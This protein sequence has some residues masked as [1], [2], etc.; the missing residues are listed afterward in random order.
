MNNTEK[1]EF[2]KEL[3]LKKQDGMDL[4]MKLSMFII[5][6][7]LFFQSLAAYFVLTLLF[8][9]SLSTLNVGWFQLFFII[10]LA[11]LISSTMGFVMLEK[12]KLIE[13]TNRIND[14]VIHLIVD[15]K[16]DIEEYKVF[17]SMMGYVSKSKKTVASK[18]VQF[19][20]DVSLLTLFL[21]F[22]T[23]NI[24]ASV[25][26]AL[27]VNIIY[28]IFYLLI[29]FRPKNKTYKMLRIVIDS[30]MGNSIFK[31]KLDKFDSLLNQFGDLINKR[32]KEEMIN[33]LKQ[34]L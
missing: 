24:Q 18:F 16:L 4:G 3:K 29:K 11:D 31:E 20:L 15:E 21:T 9:G 34:N 30:E 13:K 2:L 32:D 19:L 25:F 12:N 22:A 6:I 27:V 10:F 26:I 5:P 23:S 8:K 7:M 28:Y 17:D 33:Y 1:E 14:K